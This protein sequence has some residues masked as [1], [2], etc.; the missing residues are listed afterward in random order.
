MFG[1]INLISSLFPKSIYGRFLLMILLP[2]IIIQIVT[3]V[4]FYE[5]HWENVSNHMESYL[6]SEIKTVT[7]YYVKYPKQNLIL[8]DL[9][10]LDLKIRLLK[11]YNEHKK[12][13][14]NVLE[15]FQNKLRANIN[16]NAEVF[17]VDHKST[18][19][20]LIFL[21]KDKTLQI[22]FSAK[23][24]TNPT[25]YIFVIWI[26]VT[27]ILFGLISLFFMRNQVKS[28][29]KLTEAAKDFGQGKI[30]H[31][32]PSGAKEIRSLGVSFLKMRQNIE[33][34][35]K[36]RT[37]LLAHIAHD[38]RTPITR[39]KLKLALLKKSE[40]IEHINKNLNKIESMIKSYLD[41]AKQE[42]NEEGKKYDLIKLIK[43]V[44]I[45]FA[46]KRIKFRTNKPIVEM[47]LKSMA[48]ERA[49]T[50]V[51]DNALK[52]TATLV[53]IN[54]LSGEDEAVVQIDDDGPGIAEENYKLAFEPFNELN[55]KDTGGYGLGLA[56]AKNIVT[57]HGGKIS[58]A[59]NQHGGLRVIIQLPK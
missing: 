37:E 27:S 6:I 19:R 33:K 55:A 9:A 31:F 53:E 29:I 56:I 24:I 41:F 17:Y 32:V 45:S 23:R 44:I 58:L 7:N 40:D 13:I 51:V 11:R 28:I 46:D 39:I 4:I 18:I 30:Y 42:G 20:S 34:Q 54:V 26:V 43:N 22:D 38:L 36:Y 1:L 49:I 47:H 59:K 15:N 16:Y 12:I 8:E 52:H 48:I 2:I 35:I 10:Q 5:R 57:A 3:I 14:N 21:S 25:T 50:N